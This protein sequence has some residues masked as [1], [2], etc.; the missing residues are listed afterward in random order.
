MSLAFC[1]VTVFLGADPGLIPVDPA[2]LR[3]RLE[4]ILRQVAG[5]ST[6]RWNNIRFLFSKSIA[7]VTSMLPDRS[8]FPLLPS[9]DA[10]SKDTQ[11]VLSPADAKRD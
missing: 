5:V 6:R 1:K 11:R 10:F 9:W 3:R 7:M 8:V 4:G 2:N